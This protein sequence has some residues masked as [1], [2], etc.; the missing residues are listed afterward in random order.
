MTIPKKNTMQLRSF[1]PAHEQKVH[2]KRV[3]GLPVKFKQGHSL[4]EFYDA[5]IGKL[6][7]FGLDT[8]AY[9]RDVQN[10]TTKQTV[11]VIKNHARYTPNLEHNIEQ[12]NTFTESNFGDFDSL[13]SNDALEFLYDSINDQLRINLQRLV[14][15]SDCFISVWL[16]LMDQIVSAS[17]IHHEEI[18]QAVRRDYAK[19]YSGENIKLCC[20]SIKDKMKE[21]ERADEF[22]PTLILTVLGS[23]RYLLLGHFLLTFS[24]SGMR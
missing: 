14:D 4:P 18:R 7:G 12:I 19:N 5:V 11:M 21:L 2:A 20:E 9:A 6:E 15:P 3:E 10:P 8:I 17:S 1:N 16:R 23:Q 22:S 24:T 13:N